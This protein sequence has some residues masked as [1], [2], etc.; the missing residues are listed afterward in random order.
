M[1]WSICVMEGFTRSLKKGGE[2]DF[3]EEGSEEEEIDE[4]EEEIETGSGSAV[5][6]HEEE[7]EESPVKVV[8][9]FEG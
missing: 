1:I 4:A 7:A 5:K 8:G 6:S 9:K 3:V 2:F